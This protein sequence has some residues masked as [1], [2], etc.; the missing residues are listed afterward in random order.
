M[1]KKIIGKIIYMVSV[2]LGVAIITISYLVTT[3]LCYGNDIVE[4]NSDSS[5][6]VSDYIIIENEELEKIIL[7]EE[8]K[9]Q[10]R[11]EKEATRYVP[12][13]YT[14]TYTDTNGQ[15]YEAIAL[16]KIPN[17]G[18]EYQVLLSTS[19]SLLK[20]S[21]TKYWG[22]NPNEIGNLCIL[23]HNYKNSRFFGKLPT[24]QN[25]ELIQLTD[26]TGKTLDYRVYNTYV[27]DEDDN[28][29]TSQL[30]DG[31][32]D[33]TLITCYYEPGAAHATRRFVVKARAV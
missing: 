20:V 13:T 1:K 15:N 8:L 14:Y 10:I 22:G 18:I 2:T 25:N 23:G 5:E 31:N 4:A 24:I 19:D 17:L 27:V 12:Q 9:E 29:C 33:I 28:T 21:L 6:I 7:E 26:A 16:L 3:S 32:I 30:T 11:K